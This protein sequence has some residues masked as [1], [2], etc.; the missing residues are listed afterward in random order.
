MLCCSELQS[1]NINALYKVPLVIFMWQ[2]F[3]VEIFNRPDRWIIVDFY[4]KIVAPNLFV[5]FC[6]FIP[7]H[8]VACV[9]LNNLGIMLLE[10]GNFWQETAMV[11]HY[12]CSQSLM[13][14]KVIWSN[15]WD[16]RFMGSNLISMKY[17]S[18]TVF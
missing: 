3:P 13:I 1:R 11:L 16:C 9:F 7:S 2:F 15:A 6:H 12:F 8:I 17:C 14:L 5:C 4:Q 10:L 18:Q